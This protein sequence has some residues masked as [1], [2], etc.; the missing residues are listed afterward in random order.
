MSSVYPAP[1]RRYLLYIKIMWRRVA[2]AVVL[3]VSAACASSSPVAPDGA[4]DVEIVLAPAQ[5]VW[6]EAASAAV[7]FVGVT[8]DSRCPADAF[9]ILGGSAAVHIDVTGPRDQTAA[10]ELQTAGGRPVRYRD[11]TIALVQLSPFPFSGRPIAP[12]EYRA[13]LRITR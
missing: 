5:S 1:I 4:V 6:I 12:G 13:T 8:G 10:Y 3:A 2:L 7:A 9:C 11:L